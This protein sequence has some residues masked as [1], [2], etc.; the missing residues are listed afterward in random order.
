MSIKIGIPLWI[1]NFTG[2]SI[3]EVIN[4]ISTYRIDLIEISIDYPWPYKEVD[5]LNN[6]ILEAINYDIKISLHAPWRDI[7]FATPYDYLGEHIIKLLSQILNPILN[8]LPYETYIVL[9]P[10]TMQRIDILNN[11]KDIVSKTRKR[12]YLLRELINKNTSILLENLSRGFGSE[13]SYLREIVLGLDKYNVGLCLD[14]GHLATRYFRELD[15]VYS[16]FYE[17]LREVITMLNDIYIPTVH[18]HDTDGK[19]HEHILIGEGKLDFKKVLK[20]LSKLKPNH[21]IYEMFRSRKTKPT[22][23]EILKIVAG[24]R[25]WVRI[26]MH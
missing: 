18:L 19:T 5:L 12:M 15:N 1:G 17:Y 10:L 16:D 3:E 22:L 20:T 13:P 21:I 14:I 11:R 25:T 9:H 24:Q 4:L 2:H 26:Y 23:E 8:K 7:P 6:L